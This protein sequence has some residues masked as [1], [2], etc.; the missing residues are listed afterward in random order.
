LKL[1]KINR[2]LDSPSF[3]ITS[4]LIL[5]IMKWCTMCALPILMKKAS[6][7]STAGNLKKKRAGSAIT[8]LLKIGLKKPGD[9]FHMNRM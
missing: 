5:F 8:G 1:I 7:I 2:L 6:I 3:P 9:F 4:F